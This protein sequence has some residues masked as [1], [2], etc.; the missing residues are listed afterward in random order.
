[1]RPFD[2]L[3]G[4]ETKTQQLIN[5]AYGFCGGK[6]NYYAQ[7]VMI[8]QCAN[9]AAKLSWDIDNN[10]LSKQEEITANDLMLKMCDKIYGEENKLESLM[11]YANKEDFLEAVFMGVR[12][13]I[14]DIATNATD[15]PC[16][17]FYD[18]IKDGVTKAMSEVSAK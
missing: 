13:G 11:P 7:S 5:L 14:M 18:S 9:K 2:N 17:D 1:M 6:D 10:C 8:Q 3:D 16:H 12:C 4:R 15:M